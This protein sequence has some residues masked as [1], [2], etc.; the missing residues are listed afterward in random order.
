MIPIPPPTDRTAS[1]NAGF[2]SPAQGY[3]QTAIDFNTLLVK[4]PA[5]TYLFRLKSDELAPLGI[6]KGATLIVDR[7]RTPQ[8]DQKAVIQHEGE[9]LCRLLTE[10]NGK[11]LFTNGMTNIIPVPNETQI[12]GT[13]TAYIVDCV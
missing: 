3:E 12:I 5:A 9:F 7:S 10:E 8:I 2:A 6:P 1:K 4:N 13:V 11:P